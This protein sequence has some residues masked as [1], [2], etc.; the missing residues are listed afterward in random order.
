MKLL[1]IS[2][3]YFLIVL[4]IIMTFSLLSSKLKGE[5]PSLFGYEAKQVLSGSMEPVI[6]TGSIVIMNKNYNVKELT[7]GD[8]I[9]YTKESYSVTHRIVSINERRGN[10]SL[11]TQGDKNQFPDKEAVLPMQIT[12]LYTGIT[13]P[14][15]GYLLNLINTK[16]GSFLF[17]IIPGLLCLLYAYVIFKPITFNKRNTGTHN[18]EY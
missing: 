12:G 1:L 6:P 8:I 14:K 7:E 3:Y 15:A 2:L 11:V 16:L 18:N 13:I 10:L 9:T 5:D 17:F 4:S